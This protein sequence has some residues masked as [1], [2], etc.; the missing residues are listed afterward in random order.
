MNSIVCD[1]SLPK[2]ASFL[3]SHVQSLQIS[4]DEHTV[5][6]TVDHGSA[7]MILGRKHESQFICVAFLLHN[8]PQI[9][10]VPHCCLEGQT[11]CMPCI[12]LCCRAKT[13][14]G[15]CTNFAHSNLNRPQIQVA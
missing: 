7:L 12:G 14:L 6:G 5:K 3:C 9:G 8:T 11:N 13:K 4:A 1:E 2:L 10:L 15:N